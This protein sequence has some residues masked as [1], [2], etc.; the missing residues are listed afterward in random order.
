MAFCVWVLSLTVMISRFSHVFFFCSILVSRCN[1]HNIK[2]TIFK[3]T[4]IQRF[5]VYSQHCASITAI[6]FQNMSIIPKG[7]CVLVSN[8]PFL[9]S[10]GKIQLL[11]HMS[12]SHSFLRPKVPSYEY[13]V[14]FIHSLVDSHFRVCFYFLAIMNKAAINIHAP[15]FVR[16]YIFKV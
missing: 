1:S 12:A 3:C 9:L 11:Q 15:V 14:L 10:P 6:S 8:P 16:T 2:F 5:L 13:H 4:T 7:N